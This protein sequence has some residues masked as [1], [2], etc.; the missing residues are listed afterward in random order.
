M[1]RI[2]RKKSLEDDDI[3]DNS[4]ASRTRSYSLPLEHSYEILHTANGSSF[5]GN[6][7]DTNVFASSGV[8]ERSDPGDVDIDPLATEIQSLA[9]SEA[10]TLFDEKKSRLH[11]QERYIDNFTDYLPFLL[12]RLRYNNEQHTPEDTHTEADPTSPVGEGNVHHHAADYLYDSGD[13]LPTMINEPLDDLEPLEGNEAIVSKPMHNFTIKRECILASELFK[14]NSYLFPSMESFQIFRLL[15][16]KLRKML[17]GLIYLYDKSGGIRMQNS[18]SKSSIDHSDTIDE[19]QHIIPLN[20]K[21]KGQGLPLFKYYVPYMQSFRRSTPF[22]VFKRYKEIPDAPSPN[23]KVDATGLDADFE[24]YTYCTVQTKFS[25]DLR[26]FVFSFTPAGESGFKIILFQHNFKPFADF[27]YKGTRFRVVGTTLATG[28]LASYSPRMKLMII[29]DNAPS[30]CDNLVD[31]K[32]GFEIR[33]IVKKKSAN[34]RSESSELLDMK[35]PFPDPSSPLLDSNLLDFAIAHSRTAKY[36]PRTKPPFGAMQDSMTYTNSST[37]LPKK[38]SEAGKFELYQDGTLL[39]S[40]DL[41]STL[42]FDTD[43]LVFNCILLSL[44]EAGIRTANRGGSHN[45]G[46]SPGL[47]MLT[48]G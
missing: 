26:R 21:V 4:L 37:L 3:C 39:P 12:L 31:K 9:L 17:R 30:L 35:N 11:L 1:K 24:T 16:S 33:S 32:A 47:R 10:D 18:R 2:F 22:V 27:T 6:L 5:R 48:V 25:H 7:F 13:D 14:S 38:F 46:I 15:R 40:E 34:G 43:T 36:V 8:R 42:S 28:Y 20:F 45:I 23:D 19:R 29:D 41:D 44:R